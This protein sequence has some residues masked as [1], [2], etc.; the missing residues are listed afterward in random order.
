M[1]DERAPSLFFATDVDVA[2]ASQQTRFL[3]QRRHF[4]GVALI[5]GIPSFNE[6]VRTKGNV[7][8]P[9]P[10]VGEHLRLAMPVLN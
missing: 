10:F 8:R 1:R 6:L 4:G 3:W 2:P 9:L 7:I 5:P